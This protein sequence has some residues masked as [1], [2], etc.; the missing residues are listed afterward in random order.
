MEL[1]KY[2]GFKFQE[3]KPIL[4][5]ENISYEVRE[6]YDTKGTKVGDDLRIIKIKKEENI[7]IYVAYF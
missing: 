1:E 7:I 3:V 5:S 6:V 2:I 4:D